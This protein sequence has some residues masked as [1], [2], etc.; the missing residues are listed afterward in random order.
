MQILRV[1]AEVPTV[2]ELGSGDNPTIEAGHDHLDLN[3]DCPH[4]EFHGD[5]R[6]VFAPQDFPDIGNL[7][8]VEA[9]YYDEVQAVHFIEHIEWTRQVD[10]FRAVLGWLKPG[11]EFRVETPNFPYIL[12]YYTEKRR[13]GKFPLDE[14]PAITDHDEPGALMRWINFKL[15]SGC[16]P[17]DYHHCVFDKRLREAVYRE[18]GFTDV[19]VSSKHT[20]V[21]MGRKPGAADPSVE[22]Y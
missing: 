8:T 19:R 7:G 17:G 4:I 15:N 21:A 22:Y 10:L 20:L 5:I 3:T 14:H 11:G 12:R 13:R 9:D 6:A 18:A 1:A 2:L 16:S